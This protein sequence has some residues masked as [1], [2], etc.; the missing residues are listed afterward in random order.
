MPSAAKQSTPPPPPSRR[1]SLS[2]EYRSSINEYWALEVHGDQNVRVLPH[3]SKR[4]AKGWVHRNCALAASAP[5]LH[6]RGA[7][8][9]RQTPCGQGCGGGNGCGRG[10]E[11][12]GGPASRH[13]ARGPA[14][15]G[16]AVGGA[17]DAA[18]ARRA[19]R[20]PLA[21]GAAHVGVGRRAVDAVEVKAGGVVEPGQG[22]AGR[23]GAHNDE[24]A[25]QARA[26]DTAGPRLQ[27]GK[28]RRNPLPPPPNRVSLVGPRLAAV[29][30]L[31]DL[32]LVASGGGLAGDL[33]HV[34]VEVAVGPLEGAL[35]QVLGDVPRPSGALRSV[36]IVAFGPLAS[37]HV[38][39]P[40][41]ARTP[42]QGQGST[43]Q[44]TVAPRQAHGDELTRGEARKPWCAAMLGS[45]NTTS[46]CTAAG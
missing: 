37:S 25:T 21:H 43:R 22:G 17:V 20:E 29:G 33:A 8:C 46:P 34:L 9:L 26:T 24:A 6:A 11:G 10:G 2:V 12:E 36:I 14:P 19:V 7:H 16:A 30:G 39:A 4:P 40:P 38:P 1:T 35:A 45:G 27:Q 32:G 15:G 31:G 13:A 5:T 41:Y 42:A 18:A 23:G 3:H 44:R 28:P